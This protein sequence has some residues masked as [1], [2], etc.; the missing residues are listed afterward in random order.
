LRAL[1]TEL[2]IGSQ[3]IKNSAIATRPSPFV[4]S[5]VYHQVSEG[6][7]YE[8]FKM[9]SLFI[10]V[11]LFGRWVNENRKYSQV[12]LFVEY[13]CSQSSISHFTLSLSLSLSSLNSP[14]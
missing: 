3:T 9:S 5:P 12:L 8:G 6:D 10:S 7:F 13:F 2:R 11:S 1:S 14:P 4:D